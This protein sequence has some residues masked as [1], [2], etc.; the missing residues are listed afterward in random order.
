MSSS[1]SVAIGAAGRFGQLSMNMQAQSVCSRFEVS[2][3]IN[4]HL[5]QVI[6]PS[7]LF[8]EV[9]VCAACCWTTTSLILGLRRFVVLMP[10]RY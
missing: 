1:A 9:V 5:E 2:D 8:S 3:V 10:D 4:F 6:I 7:W